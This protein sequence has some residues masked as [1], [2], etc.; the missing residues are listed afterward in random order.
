[1]TTTKS[2]QAVAVVEAHERAGYRLTAAGIET[3]VLDRGHGEPVV[4]LHGV[5][6]SS[7]LYRKVID[8]LAVRGL[9]GIAFDLPG[10]GLADRP[11]AFDYSW[12]GLGQFA[13]AAV[14]ALGLNGFHLVV[15]DIGAPVGFELAARH[16]GRVKS[17]TVLNAPVAVA[18]FHRPL[19]MKPFAVRGIG[20][21]CLRL[22]NPPM[23]R[24]L[25]RWQGIA[26]PS[27]TTDA[28]LD[29]YLVLLRRTDRGRAF[30]TIMRSFE[31]TQTKQ[32]L[33]QHILRDSGIRVQV[34]WGDA[35]PALPLRTRGEQARQV[36]GVTTIHRLPARH[37]LQEDQAPA[38]A[39]LI[40]AHVHL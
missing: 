33:Y 11:S 5:P 22:L 14:D 28:E 12:T 1:M 8:E 38:L 31:L 2:A 10:L 26:D 40:T 36:A 3:F 9:R 34:I 37:F 7:F 32:E 35:D 6:A 39:D 13:A 30:L 15:H 18:S 4:C 21:A 25:M 17:L 19:I 23:F 24:R 20:D 16:S 29:S 27:A